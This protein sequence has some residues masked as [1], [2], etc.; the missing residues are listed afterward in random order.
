MVGRLS[1]HRSAPMCFVICPDWPWPSPPLDPPAPSPRPSERP[2]EAPVSHPDPSVPQKRPSSL[3]KRFPHFIL[4][5]EP[6]RR[7]ADNY[8]RC[9]PRVRR[10]PNLA[11]H[12]G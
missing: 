5:N 8:S 4:L 7:K 10:S 2:D 3:N 9:P 1:H 6:P 11:N 12:Q